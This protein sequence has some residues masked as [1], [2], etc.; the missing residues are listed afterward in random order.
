MPFDCSSSCSLLFYYFYVCKSLTF[1][2]KYEFYSIL[3]Y[4][5]L[6]VNDESTEAFWSIIEL[7]IMSLCKIIKCQIYQIKENS[8]EY[9]GLVS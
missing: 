6:Q 1:D 3:F 9:M 7:L 5:I 8:H 2:V 4:S